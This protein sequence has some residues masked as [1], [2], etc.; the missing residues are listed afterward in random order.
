MSD[1]SLDTNSWIE[2]LLLISQNELFHKQRYC[3][4][5]GG[6]RGGTPL[7]SLKGEVS[8]LRLWFFFYVLIPKQI[9]PFS[10]FNSVSFWA[11]SLKQGINDGGTRPVTCVVPAVCFL[12][13]LKLLS[14]FKIYLNLNVKIRNYRSYTG[15]RKKWFLYLTGTGS[16]EGVSST[17]LPP[18]F[19]RFPRDCVSSF[20][21]N[22]PRNIRCSAHRGTPTELIEVLS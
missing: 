9:S 18:H 1:H 20:S 15:Q 21:Q 16:A 19:L 3:F 14:Q 11:N 5:R 6:G 17:P 10:V 22:I 12:K 8:P 4:V 2:K 13:N 7:S